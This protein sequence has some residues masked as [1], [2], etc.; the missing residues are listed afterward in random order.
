MKI[1]LIGPK[2]KAGG[3]ARFVNDFCSANLPIKLILYDTARPLK[4]TN[5][6]Y[7]INSYSSILNA[8]LY[9]LF[10][11]IL[12]TSRKALF[13]PIKLYKI[14]PDIIYVLGAGYITFWDACLYVLLSWISRS[15]IIFHWLGPLEPFY[16]SSPPI[17]RSIIHFVLKRINASI[18][19]TRNDERLLACLDPKKPLLF[20]PSSV[21]TENFLNMRTKE[22]PAEKETL[23]TILFQ[24][25]V[26]P[27]R[28]GISTLFEAIPLVLE[29]NDIPIHFI[30]TGNKA[31]EDLIKRSGFQYNNKVTCRGW[32][33]EVEKINIY[34]SS[35]L[36]VLPSFDEGMPYSLVEAMAAGLPIV[37][38]NV[39][40]IPDLIKNG[41]NG[42][43]V[44]PGCPEKLA[45]Y[46]TLIIKDKMLYRYISENNKNKAANDYSIHA[47]FQKIM[48]LCDELRPKN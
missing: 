33:D 3:F 38:T 48:H 10:Q 23:F 37:S 28:K 22:H 9:R 25:G 12:I 35:H 19:L 36:M 11:S 15:K 7:K 40:G 26:D 39:G 14:K 24:G 45:E 46:I 20:I 43:L 44:P 21:D 5:K 1:L 31:S 16:Y 34:K 13:Y 17:V 30:I 6:P 2:L 41:E 8:G 29:N 4:I 32:V 27:Y 42:F 18:V 47:M